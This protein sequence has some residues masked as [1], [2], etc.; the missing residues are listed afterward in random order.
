MSDQLINPDCGGGHSAGFRFT[1][2]RVGAVLS[3]VPAASELS[4]KRALDIGCNEGAFSRILCEK[5]YECLGIDIDDKRIETARRSLNSERLKFEVQNATELG[6]PDGSYDLILCLEVIE[7]LDDPEKLLDEIRRVMKPEGLLIISTP[8]NCSLEGLAGRA[9][10]A[11]GGRRWNAWDPTHQRI[12][13]SL[14]FLRLMDRHRFRPVRIIGYYYW[15]S[16]YRF[17]RMR[18][19][20]GL[21]S[22]FDPLRY[23]CCSQFPFNRLGFDIIGAFSLRR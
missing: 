19:L 3:L 23:A 11:I 9:L 13:S 20:N 1:E 21:Q 16:V 22:V 12:Y 14:E 8:N 6:T 17:E 18:L 10:Q 7:H 4:Q 2:R 5:G 15:P